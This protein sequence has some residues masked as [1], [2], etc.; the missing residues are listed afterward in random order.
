VSGQALSSISNF[1]GRESFIAAVVVRQRRS[2]FDDTL[3]DKSTAAI[4]KKCLRR[5]QSNEVIEVAKS[6]TCPAKSL[7][8]PV[9]KLLVGRIRKRW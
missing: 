1:L 9:K 6:G 4:R 5:V 7:R 8:F 3:E 2:P